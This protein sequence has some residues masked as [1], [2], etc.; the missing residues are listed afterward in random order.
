MKERE[1][2][3]G[4]SPLKPASDAGFEG[5]GDPML[6]TQGVRGSNPLVSTMKGSRLPP[7][8]QSWPLRNVIPVLECG[9]RFTYAPPVWTD[10]DAE[11]LLKV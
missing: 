9:R 4:L 3:Q 7:G 6:C 11:L 1:K 5:C 10:C 8:S 2:K